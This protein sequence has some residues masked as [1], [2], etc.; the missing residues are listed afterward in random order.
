MHLNL[1]SHLALFAIGVLRSKR[2]HTEKFAKATHALALS[3]VEMLQ[4]LANEIVCI[5][6]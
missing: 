3:G 2:K 1:Q 6:L 5:Y 4:K